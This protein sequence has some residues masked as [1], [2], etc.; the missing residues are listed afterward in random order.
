MTERDRDRQ[1]DIQAETETDTETD[2]QTDRDTERAAHLR[3]LVER[4]RQTETDRQRH[5]SE[6]LVYFRALPRGLTREG[7]GK[8]LYG[9]KTVA[10]VCKVH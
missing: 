3:S 9:G 1:T 6:R 4:D 7:R 2:R 5:T 8:V 10:G